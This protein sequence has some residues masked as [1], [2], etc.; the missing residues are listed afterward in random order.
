V[1]QAALPGD[2]TVVSRQRSPLAAKIGALTQTNMS[3]A[4]PCF[5]QMVTQVICV[6]IRNSGANST[7]NDV[8]LASPGNLGR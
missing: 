3:T 6:D 7:R 2:R 4:L 5:D 1:P 8:V